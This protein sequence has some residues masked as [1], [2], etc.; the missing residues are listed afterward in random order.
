MKLTLNPRR[1]A[2]INYFFLCRY[3]SYKSIV[4]ALPPPPKHIPVHSIR[5]GGV[6]GGGVKGGLEGGQRKS[7]PKSPLRFLE[8]FVRKRNKLATIHRGTILPPLPHVWHSPPA[9]AP[10]ERSPKTKNHTRAQHRHLH[11][12]LS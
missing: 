11:N 1:L 5:A 10:N 3:Q 8:S 6:R 4:N 7:D 12:I 2:L 9:S